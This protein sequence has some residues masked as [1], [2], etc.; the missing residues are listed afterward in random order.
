MRTISNHRARREGRRDGRPYN[1]TLQ[2]KEDKKPQPALDQTEP[3]PFVRELHAVAGEQIDRIEQEWHQENEA[4]STKMAVTEERLFQ[5]EEQ[6]ETIDRGKLGRSARIGHRIYLVLQSI[7]A[8]SEAIM[9]S[10]TFQVFG[11]DTGSTW[12]MSLG[13][14][15]AIPIA[16]HINGRKRAEKRDFWDI[17]ALRAVVFLGLLVIATTRSYFF[18]AEKLARLLGIEVGTWTLSLI[19]VGL[20]VVLY[21]TSEVLATEATPRDPEARAI[22]NEL[23]LLKRTLKALIVAQKQKQAFQRARATEVCQQFVGLVAAYDS[24]NQRARATTVDSGQPVWIYYVTPPD[25]PDSLNEPPGDG[26][27]PRP[28]RPQTPGRPGESIAVVRNTHQRLS[29]IKLRE[30]GDLDES[31]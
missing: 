1:R 28:P 19:F 9:S 26:S 29:P 5:L 15:V 16:A 14:A 25:I 2:G 17:W 23:E 10:L 22:L 13:P 11:Q 4:P 7:I 20:S 21:A 18:E 6:A 27:P 3:P 12:L 31:G 8:V 24:A 30:G